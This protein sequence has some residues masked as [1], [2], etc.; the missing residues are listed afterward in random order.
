MKEVSGCTGAAVLAAAVI[1]G[2]ALLHGWA[3]QTLWGWFVAPVFHVQ[4]LTLIQAIGLG[5]IV[6][7]I[8]P[9]PDIKQKSDDGTWASLATV[10]AR[11]MIAVGIGW[12]VN[13]FM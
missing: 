4:Y 1:V 2:F 3:I 7:T 5:L 11:P 9:S 6:Q 8:S 10:V 12:V 13:M